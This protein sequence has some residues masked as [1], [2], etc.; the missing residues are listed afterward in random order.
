MKARESI[1]LHPR[2]RFFAS[3]EA[4]PR[5]DERVLGEGAAAAPDHAVID[6]NPVTP[7]S[8]F[9]DFAQAFVAAAFAAPPRLDAVPDDQLTAIQAR[10]V[11]AQEDLPRPGLGHGRVANSTNGFT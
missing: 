5:I 6:L 4:S 2:E 3:P 10:G 1:P 8:E 11:H 9:C 7:A